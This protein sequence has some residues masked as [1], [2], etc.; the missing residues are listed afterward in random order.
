M[1]GWIA[2]R[3]TRRHG[4]LSESREVEVLVS[5]TVIEVGVDVPNATIML[6]QQ[7]E[8]FGLAQLHQLRGRIC[9]GS[10]Q[11]YCFLI[12]DADTPEANRAVAEPWNSR[13]TDSSLRKRT[14]NY[15]ARAMCWAHVRAVHY[16]CEWR[17]RFVIFVI[18]QTARQYGT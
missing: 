11:G 7:A 15:A 13:P 9:R 8:R 18:L 16:L 5:T 14:P 2:T 6:V 4:S 17:I 3:S 12:S 10:F 1:V